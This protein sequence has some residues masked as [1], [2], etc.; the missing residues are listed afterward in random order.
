MPTK[1]PHRACILCKTMH[2]S[3]KIPSEGNEEGTKRIF[4]CWNCAR[5]YFEKL[6]NLRID[7]DPDK[8][9]L[10]MEAFKIAKK[11]KQEQF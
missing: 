4:L 1:F 10:L 8:K 6:I 5:Q 2:V 11:V 9:Y 7:Q 3:W